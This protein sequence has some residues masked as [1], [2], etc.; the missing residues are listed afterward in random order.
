MCRLRCAVVFYRV[1]W[2][3]TRTRFAIHTGWMLDTLALR[4]TCSFPAHFL[5]PI[6]SSFFFICTT[7]I[8]CLHT[9]SS[10]T[11]YS[12]VFRT[13]VFIVFEVRL[14]P[15]SFLLFGYILSL[16]DLSCRSLLLRL[17][18]RTYQ[19]RRV[20]TLRKTYS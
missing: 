12:S 4:V 17:N 6:N 16:S 7:V 10:D 14:S 20:L 1:I 5:P 11:F 13:S 2:I 15:L 8:F 3:G 18:M 19:C 9:H